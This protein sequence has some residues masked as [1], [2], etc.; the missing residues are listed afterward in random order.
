MSWLTPHMLRGPGLP[1]VGGK[2]RAD[3]EPPLTDTPE[4][5][6]LSVFLEGNFLSFQSGWAGP[7]AA[8]SLKT[9]A[10]QRDNSLPDLP[11]G[12]M[13]GWERE[14]SREKCLE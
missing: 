12:E 2:G 13:V 4:H 10:R 14:G 9:V 7:T 8:A 3:P 5:S 11:L 6:G 1:E